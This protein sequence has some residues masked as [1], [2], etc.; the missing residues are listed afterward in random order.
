MA[1]LAVAGERPEV[2]LQA[3]PEAVEPGQPQRLVDRAHHPDGVPLQFLKADLAEAAL[4]NQGPLAEV[5]VVHLGVDG[6]DPVVRVPGRPAPQVVER[7]RRPDRVPGRAEDDERVPA[8][9]DE[10][11]VGEQVQ[12]EPDAGRVRRRLEH[13]PPAAEPE[14]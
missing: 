10:P 5:G 12:E 13:Q 4:G 8:D 3:R 2:A 6:D 9:V 14:R 1:V 11:G 7:L